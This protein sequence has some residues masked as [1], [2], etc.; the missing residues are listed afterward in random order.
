MKK[1]GVADV[2]VHGHDVFHLPLTFEH[3]PAGRVGEKVEIDEAVFGVRFREI[4]DEVGADEAGATRDEKGFLK[5]AKE[6]DGTG[7]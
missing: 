5:H 7:P 1:R 2:A 3:L 6:S 4:V